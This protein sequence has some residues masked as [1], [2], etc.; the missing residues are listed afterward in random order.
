[1]TTFILHSANLAAYPFL[2]YVFQ[3]WGERVH[4]ACLVDDEFVQN[5]TFRLLKKL[6]RVTLIAQPTE[7]PNFRLM[8]SHW[9]HEGIRPSTCAPGSTYRA[10]YVD[11]TMRTTT[12]SRSQ[13]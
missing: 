11:F 12:A 3:Y 7:K 5:H 13:G 9:I 1:M 4:R 2:Y 10:W 8:P 6:E